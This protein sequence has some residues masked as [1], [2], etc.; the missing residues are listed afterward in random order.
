MI[1][2]ALFR[3]MAPALLLTAACGSAPTRP[4]GLEDPIGAGLPSPS[5]AI[6]SPD[7]AAA[8]AILAEYSDRFK[9]GYPLQAGDKLRFVVLG[10]A[11]ISVTAYVPAEGSM[12]FPHVGRID[13]AGRT[14][15]E[16]RAE[17]ARRLADGY[18]VNPDVSI[19]VEEYAKRLV[20]VLGAIHQQHSYEIPG[21]RTV[22]LLQSIALAYGF[23]PEAE[24]RSVLI[25]RAKNAAGTEHIMIPV[26]VVALTRTGKGEDPLLIPGDVV[27]VPEREKIYVHGQVNRPSAYPISA[28]YPTTL[29]QAISMAGGFNRIAAESS[30]Q[31]TR[32][33]ANGTRATYAI[34]V[35]R[36]MEGHSE[37]D[38][39]LQPGD[40]IFVP[41]SFF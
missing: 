12:H 41:E 21:G 37:D 15:E 29:T 31:L 24:K 14:L 34:D 11:E 23:R 27:V 38:V 5:F 7:E 2:S 22:T 10:N 36:I 19:F 13:V 25:T 40:V 1:R 28:D 20:H 9:E 18:L 32:R 35:T 26:D 3:S 8:R 30:V 17:L 6:S 33:H 16:V 4:P 39:Q